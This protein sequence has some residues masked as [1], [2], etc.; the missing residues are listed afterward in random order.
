MGGRI[1]YTN[2][3]TSSYLHGRKA[4]DQARDNKL[5]DPRITIDLIDALHQDNLILKDQFFL[6]TFVL[7]VGT[8]F[9]INELATLPTDCLVKEGDNIGI[10]FFPEKTPQLDTRWLMSDWATPVHDAIKKL[11]ELTNEGREAVASLRKDPGLDWSRILKNEEATQ[12]F[13]KRFCHYW[14]SDEQHN[15]FNKTGVWVEK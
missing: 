11:T 2:T 1:S 10:R 13:V 3:L 4:N 9:R 6:L 5:I 12:Y 8:G 7:F 15:M 14:T